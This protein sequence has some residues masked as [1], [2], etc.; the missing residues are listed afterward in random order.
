MA[1]F[2]FVCY[3]QQTENFF[4]MEISKIKK[5]ENKKNM[6]IK[7]KKPTSSSPYHVKLKKKAPLP[8]WQVFPVIKITTSELGC[9]FFLLVVFTYL[10][11]GLF[12]SKK[13]K[14]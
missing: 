11:V 5:F 7:K 12:C 13:K 3:H 14:K 2:L 10:P 4:F 6:K 9:F 8:F 1:L